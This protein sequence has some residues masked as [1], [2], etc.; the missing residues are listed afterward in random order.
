MHQLSAWGMTG[1]I[2]TFRQGATFYRNGRDWA[3]EQRDEA[4]RLANGRVDEPPTE[5]PA[6]NANITQASS[7]DTI[8]A[9]TEESQ[10]PLTEESN[11]AVQRSIN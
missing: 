11:L 1:N 7:F 4:I 3:K 8:E 5:T 10:T 2:E 6:V 9:L